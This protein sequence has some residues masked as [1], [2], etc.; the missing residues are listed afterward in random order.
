[1]TDD[2]K[3]FAAMKEEIRRLRI[4]LWMKDDHIRGLRNEVYRLRKLIPMFRGRTDL[5][6]E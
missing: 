6:K 4:Q 2:Q 1:M 3:R 5:R